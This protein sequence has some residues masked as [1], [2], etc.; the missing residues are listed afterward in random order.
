MVP[1]TKLESWYRGGQNGPKS[2]P[3]KAKNSTKAPRAGNSWWKQLADKASVGQPLLPPSRPTSRP[4]SRP[5]KISPPT[6]ITYPIENRPRESTSLIA[7][8]PM[9]NTQNLG[10]VSE[11]LHS[12]PTHVW[13]DSRAIEPPRSSKETK[14]QNR[15]FVICERDDNDYVII[16][17]PTPPTD[18]PVES[19][20]ERTPPT[21][22]FQEFPSFRSSEADEEEGDEQTVDPTIPII[23]VIPPPEGD[24]NQIEDEERLSV[25]VAYK[26]LLKKCNGEIRMLR[27]LLPLAFI[28]SETEGIKLDKTEKLAE[29]LQEI[30]DDRRRLAKLLPLAA[31][32]CKDQGINLDPKAFK[33]FPRALNQVFK[34]RD[35]A[36]FEAQ[37]NKR[38]KERLERRVNRLEKELAD[39][40]HDGDEE[41]YIRP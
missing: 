12:S 40:R 19:Q 31:I 39:L 32:L 37:Y 23:R 24:V 28:V 17:G 34:D 5:I 41:D 7:K 15:K 36:R 22:E 16:K 6:L 38:E 14:R 9:I 26:S 1:S 21:H 29:A 11:A 3:S 35:D 8:S 18:L 13:P 4:I 27:K 30:I 2:E 20:E 33:S 25:E 10:S